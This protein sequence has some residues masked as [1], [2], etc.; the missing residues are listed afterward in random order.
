MEKSTTFRRLFTAGVV[1]AGFVV[2]AEAG[3]R[4]GLGG[5]Y[6][7]S[8]SELVLWMAM[9]AVAA[10]SP[11]PVPRRGTSVSLEPAL[12]LAAVMVFGPGL[13][14][15]LAVLARVVSG[16]AERWNPLEETLL[17]LGRAPLAVGATGVVYGA[18]GGAFGWD[19][20]LAWGQVPA[21]VGAMVTYVLVI[22]G[23]D[24]VMSPRRERE[25]EGG[26]WVA[27]VV[28]AGVR[29]MAIL[30]VGIL[31]SH[32]QIRLG[33]V[34]VALF[35]L[36][37]L[38]ARY[39]IK[40]WLDLKRGHTEMVRT[41]MAAVD[42]V[43]PFT[44]GHSYR[45]S[46]MCVQVA[47][48]MGLP[49]RE[50]EEI[51]YAALLHD[52]GR[53]ALRR[54]ILL[55]PGKLD[56]AEEEELR[57]HPRIAYE[58]LKD[59][60]PFPRAAEIV[61]AHHEQ[62]DGRGYPRGLVGDQIPIGSRIIMV[63]SAFDAMTSD[64]PYRKGLSPEDAFEELLANSGTQFFP[65]VVETLIH[66]YADGRL[67]D[68]FREED[69]D[70]FS[71]EGPNSHVVEEY[72]RRAAL[73]T[74][75]PEKVT[76]PARPGSEP[77]DEVPELLFPV[78][79]AFPDS[80]A[81]V[82][83]VGGRTPLRLEVAGLSDMGCERPNNEDAFGAFGA[84][85]EESGCL[86]VVADG[87]GGAAAGEVA[88]RT[89][90]E[91]LRAGW[92]KK[93]AEEE[94]ATVLLRS[95]ERANETI[96]EAAESEHRLHGMGTTCTALLAA[97]GVAQVA[98]VGD[99]RAYLISEGRIRQLTR[100]HTLGEELRNVVGMDPSQVQ[101]AQHVLTRS[102]GTQPG[103]EVD[104]LPE[105][106]VLEAGQTFVLCSD[107]LSNMVAEE[108]ILDIV[109]TSAPEEACRRLVD[110]ARERGG[111]DNITV[112]VARVIAA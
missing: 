65:D 68:A 96:H 99:S 7:P 1:L 6:H 9:F 25:A 93:D 21:L 94:G 103:I 102:L 18:L 37:L 48:R 50:I 42:A 90:V 104:T 12:D 100:D 74:T 8:T 43:D 46:K 98:H 101:E 16:A 66:L 81:G 60:A 109:G 49:D 20:A 41:L 34:G 73:R 83:P 84:D 61:Y 13:A 33:P 63:V 77:P 24:A 64:R 112:Q 17:K 55:K 31:L 4:F 91:V 40:L 80:H 26:A 75:I 72:L 87:M 71:V 38:L 14:C 22:A 32:T 69:L 45:I 78:P 27:A 39:A 57:A 58:M 53:T 95:V 89:A 92:G 79:P 5:G 29:G 28:S 23:V 86:L 47:R 82:F 56:A 51:E 62:P 30:P 110:L 36:P 76:T 19:L 70:R 15:W 54:E 35:L 108:E 44:K 11:I 111:P 85:G 59:L 107:G 2:L 88:S 106:L 10:V 97:D 52:I 67:F 3:R 105:P